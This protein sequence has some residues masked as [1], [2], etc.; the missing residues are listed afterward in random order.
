MLQ[1]SCKSSHSSQVPGH[2]TTPPAKQPHCCFHPDTHG[3]CWFSSNRTVFSSI[4]SL[5]IYMTT[6]KQWTPL[7]RNRPMKLCLGLMELKH[8][9]RVQFKVHHYHPP[10]W[11]GEEQ[12]SFAASPDSKV[13]KITVHSTENVSFGSSYENAIHPIHSLYAPA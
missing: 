2:L 13:E 3:L 1:P 6:E 9:W 11:G 4:I 5:L 10:L 8:W 7:Q 12:P